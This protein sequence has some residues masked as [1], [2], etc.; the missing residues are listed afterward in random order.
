[1]DIIKIVSKQE[2]TEKTRENLIRKSSF[3]DQVQLI[4][5]LG[6]PLFSWIDLSITDLCNRAC[7]FC[8]RVDPSTYP[9][10]NLHM[11]LSLVE[12][13]SAELSSLNYKGGVVLCGYG[14]P[15]LHPEVDRLVSVFSEKEIRV[16]I[17][18]NGDRLDEEMI[19]KLF[20]A[21][22]SFVCVSMYDSP[23]QRE[24]FTAMFE[25]MGIGQEKYIL[26]DRWHGEKD[27][28]GLK[29][30]NRAGVIDFGSKNLPMKSRCFYPAYSL[31]IDWNGDVLL[32]V[33][34][35]N[36]RVK[37]GNIFSDNL[38]DVWTSLRLQ[39]YRES[40]L[41]ANRGKSPCN[42]CNADG[43]LHGFNHANEWSRVATDA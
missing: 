3:I 42:S 7:E 30:T 13:M 37:F 2:I 35:W 19:H 9:N 21:G 31:T 10:Q 22:M 14:E 8:P 40:L 24:Y 20:S 12:K 17:V 28:F 43:T 34:D 27:E 41:D 11:S 32:C 25:S 15:L 33:Q 1:M 5:G 4:P 29:L 23:D 38:L 36:K 18:T 26:R 39:K 6:V 16:E